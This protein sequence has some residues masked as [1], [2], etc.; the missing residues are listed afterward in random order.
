MNSIFLLTLIVSMMW[1]ERNALQAADVYDARI[2]TEVTGNT[3]K[4]K[5]VLVNNSTKQISLTYKFK[6]KRIGRSG[7]SATRQ[8]GIVSAT[9]RETV[10]LSKTSVSF[11]EGDKYELH[12]ALYDGS[13]QVAEEIISYSN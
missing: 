1:G 8:S 9:P 11:S 12:L 6:C 10:E 4:I 13:R 3:L 7:S 2:E 5:N